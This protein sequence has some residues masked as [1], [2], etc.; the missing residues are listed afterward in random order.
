[1]KTDEGLVR[2]IGFTGLTAGMINYMIGAGIFVLPALVAAQV[3]AAAPV[4]YIICAVAMGLIV[5]CFADAGSR[6]S[7]SG[8]TYAYAGTAFGPYVGFIVGASYWFGSTVLAAAAVANVFVDTLAELSPTFADRTIRAL[9]LIAMFALFAAINI[10]GVK[11]GSRTVKTVTLAK[12]T[13]LLVLI[14]A[15]LFAI[16]PQYLAWPGMP[17]A[18]VT[19]RTAVILMFA[20]LGIEGGLSPSGEV[21][22]C[23][24]TV[25]RSI[26]AT[27][28]I[29]VIM[30]MALQ[31]VALGVLG[32][33]LAENQKAPLAEAAR[34]V[35]GNPGFLLV[36]AGAAISTF[37]YV[38]GD[39]LAAP[40]GLYALARDGLMP[41]AIASIHPTYRTPWI[42]ILI[43][44]VFALGFALTGTFQSLIIVATLATLI[45]YLICC[46]ATIQLQRLDI[47]A[48]GA[49]PFRVPGGPV[50]PVLAIAVVIWLMSSSTRQEFIAL[51]IMLGVETLIYLLMV[52]G[53]KKAPQRPAAG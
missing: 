22:D 23:A 4:I 2:E 41:S 9:M 25:P 38:A 10:R 46:A 28:A 34:V 33:A 29:V 11:A 53:R 36:L 43:H 7:L 42:A 13:P 45:V 27:L 14:A 18:D 21:K 15:G 26:A 17:S 12:L 20:F 8:G 52:F 6:V 35:L 51:G 47:R 48:D 39:M 49:I 50:I 30:Y 44:A 1:M 31:L 37:G 5:A 16:N 24:R 3:G 32:P 19:A 40:R